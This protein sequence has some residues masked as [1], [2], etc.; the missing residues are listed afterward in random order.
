MLRASSSHK[1]SVAKP[2]LSHCQLHSFSVLTPWCKASK[3]SLP[4]S[5]A[6]A[7]F[8][9]KQVPASALLRCSELLGNSSVP[10]LKWCCSC[11]GLGFK[12]PPEKGRQLVMMN[13]KAWWPWSLW[14]VHFGDP[15]EATLSDNISIWDHCWLSVSAS[16]NSVD[17]RKINL[18]TFGKWSLAF[19]VMPWKRVTQ[20]FSAGCTGVH[21]A[22][23][24]LLMFSQQ[25]VFLEMH[26][27]FGLCL[28]SM[29]LF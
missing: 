11:S 9:R 10:W 3:Y 8:C 5:S 7:A 6:A 29:S 24:W 2:I 25:D 12:T 20:G 18:L 19:S 27:Y 23:P 21:F 1:K 14:I 15:L 4:F 13:F 16:F 17:W 26:K 28:F 22:F